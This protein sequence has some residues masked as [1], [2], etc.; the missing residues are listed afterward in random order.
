MV[1]A[2]RRDPIPR[3]LFLRARRPIRPTDR[4]NTVEPIRRRRLSVSRHRRQVV[5]SGHAARGSSHPGR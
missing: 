2:Y 3:G 1:S 4:V 5:T